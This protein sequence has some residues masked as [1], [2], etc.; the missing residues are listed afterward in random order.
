MDIKLRQRMIERCTGHKDIWD[1]SLDEFIEKVIP[2]YEKQILKNNISKKVYSLAMQ[3]L[4]LDFDARKLA[5]TVEYEVANS[6]EA[7]GIYFVNVVG[8]S[9]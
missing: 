1:C 4:R 6:I 3:F 9:I 2:E 5:G 8:E 7:A